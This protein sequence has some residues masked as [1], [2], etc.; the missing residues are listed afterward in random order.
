MDTRRNIDVETT[1]NWRCDVNYTSLQRR[2]PA[3]IFYLNSKS[4]K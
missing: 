1:S 2:V 4:H 3:G